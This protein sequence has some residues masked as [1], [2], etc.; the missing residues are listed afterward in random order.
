[1]KRLAFAAAVLVQ[2]VVLYAPRAPATDGIPL[3]GGV[4]DKAVHAAVFAAVAWTG[5][6]AGLPALPLALVLLAHAVVSE[7]LQHWVLPHRSGDPWDAVAD[8]TGV[9][10][11]LLIAR[12]SG[13]LV[14]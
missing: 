14:S 7:L 11:G 6:R 3:V 12:R 5:R 13:R 4:V 2:L 9:L 1:M 8:A 10:V